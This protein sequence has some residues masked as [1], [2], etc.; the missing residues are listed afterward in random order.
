MN[1]QP[2]NKRRKISLPRL[3]PILCLFCDICNE[4][5]YNYK[6]CQNNC[7]Y[8]SNDCSSVLMLN[9][10]N[11]QEN[12]DFNSCQYMVFQQFCYD[13]EILFQW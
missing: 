9:N 10:M 6:T 4:K 13:F 3:K 8:C 12:T 5:V 7:G 2:P 11:N 1:D